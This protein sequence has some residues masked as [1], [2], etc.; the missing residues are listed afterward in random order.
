[1]EDLEIRKAVAVEVM[2]LDEVSHAPSG[3]NWLVYQPDIA[4]FDKVPKYEASIGA[5]WL[6]V[7]KMRNWSGRMADAF[8]ANLCLEN[9]TM[10][11]FTITPEAICKAALAAVR[12]TK[13]S[14]VE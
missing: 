8:M 14:G 9:G 4:S 3:C 2:G 13:Q 1:M 7:E 12:A 5:A 11:I 6:V 10:T